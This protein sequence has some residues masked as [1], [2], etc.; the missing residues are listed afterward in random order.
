VK[1]LL[2]AIL[3]SVASIVQAQ[4]VIE[5]SENLGFGFRRVTLAKAVNTSFESVGHFQYL[6][7]HDQQLSGVGECSISP[8]G[9]FAIYQDGSSGNLFLFRRT[10]RRVNPLS[11]KFIALVERFEWHESL[12]AVDV[13]FKGHRLGTFTLP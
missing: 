4:S 10:D 5:R 2:F 1:V 3:V 12:N 13:H 7:Y 8:S 6:Y 9:K 11:R